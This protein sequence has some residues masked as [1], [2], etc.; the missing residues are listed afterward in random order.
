MFK[1][2]IHI[3]ETNSV[4]VTFHKKYT[5]FVLNNELYIVE[6]SKDIITIYL[7]SF[8]SISE[9]EDFKFL[10]KDFEKIF[11]TSFEIKNKIFLINKYHVH[12]KCDKI[13]DD[14]VSKYKNALTD[15]DILIVKIKMG[16]YDIQDL[17][18]MQEAIANNTPEEE[19]EEPEILKVD[20]KSPKKKKEEHINENIEIPDYIE[21]TKLSGE[22]TSSKAN[23]NT[24]S[25]KE[26]K[27]IA[28]KLKLFKYTSMSKEEL[29]EAIKKAIGLSQ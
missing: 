10:I 5:S 18:S 26:L 8:R 1:F 20:R 15:I 3:Q 24:Y 4:T 6:V 28:Q 2:A 9:D 11:S 27:E 16:L 12:I 22:R 21:V 14:D 19:E 7:G 25:L 13:K 23:P 29:V 17:L